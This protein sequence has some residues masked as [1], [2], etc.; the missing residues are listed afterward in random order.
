M[1]KTVD[2][3]LAEF[4]KKHG[5]KIGLPKTII[6]KTVGLPTGNLAIDYLTGVG[7]L[8]GR[9]IR[10]SSVSADFEAGNSGLG[11]DLASS[12]AT[13]WR[14]SGKAGGAVSPNCKICR[15]ESG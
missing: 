3:L 2:D 15:N 12:S 10:G 14:I 7:G 8:P 13:I 11:E 9:G 5:L 1:P 6:D 4:D